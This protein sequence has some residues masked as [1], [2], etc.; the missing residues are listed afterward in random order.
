MPKTRGSY[1]EQELRMTII[2]PE[3]E[4]TL[5]MKTW[6]KGTDYSIVL[7]TAPAKEKGQ[8]FS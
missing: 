2:R 4:R 8:G 5:A 7:I 6:S 1:L 3:W